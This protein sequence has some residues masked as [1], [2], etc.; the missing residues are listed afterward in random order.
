MKMASLEIDDLL[1]GPLVTWVSLWI[2]WK[3]ISD[4]WINSIRK[5]NQI[6]YLNIDTIK[7]HDMLIVH[8]C[9]DSLLAAWK[10]PMLIMKI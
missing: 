6:V 3:D 9:L 8:F 2:S 1:T 10:I 4:I 7:L 5:Y